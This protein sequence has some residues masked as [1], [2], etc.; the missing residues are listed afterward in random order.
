MNKIND[1]ATYIVLTLAVLFVIIY[2]YG[3]F[4]PPYWQSP[5][6]TA[7]I[8][9][10]NLYASTN[11]ITYEEPLNAITGGGVAIR[12]AINVNT[13]VLPTTFIGIQTTHGF[14]LRLIQDSLFFIQALFGILLVLFAYLIAREI[15]GQEYATGCAIIL[16]FTAPVWYFSSLMYNNITAASLFTAGSYFLLKALKDDKLKHYIMMGLFFGAASQMRYMELVFFSVPLGIVVLTSPSLWRRIPRFAVAAVAF[17]VVFLPILLFNANYFGNPTSVGYVYAPSETH[18][19]TALIERLQYYL[20][21]AS[22]LPKIILATTSKYLFTFFFPISV[23]AFIGLLMMLHSYRAQITEH[24]KFLLFITLALIYITLY[25][26]SGVFNGFTAPKP[27]IQSSYVR[28]WLLTY[29]A[30]SLLTCFIVT[31]VR[32]PYLKAIVLTGL[33]IVNLNILLGTDGLQSTFRSTYSYEKL[34]RLLEN[35]TEPAALIFT[36]RY[37]SWLRSRKT[38]THLPIKGTDLQEAARIICNLLN[39]TVPVYIIPGKTVVHPKILQPL[40]EQACGISFERDKGIR[41]ERNMEMY[42]AVKIL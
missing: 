31:A 34:T 11:G 23:L 9:F 36:Y 19:T 6:E 32:K 14:F 24:K 42:K 40:T 4:L 3:N 27:I 13:T 38:A 30:M 41:L 28:Y 12:Q 33:I 22:F 35:H 25:Y 39:E 21:P 29:V 18:T 8:F 1:K 15:F 7:N 20:L 17:I 5:D 10:I 2:A 26:G 37:G 16:F